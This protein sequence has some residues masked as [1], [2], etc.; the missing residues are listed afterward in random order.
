[1]NHYGVMESLK[2][3]HKLMMK[4]VFTF[5]K[6]YGGDPDDLWSDAVWGFLQAYQTQDDNRASF[7]TWVQKRVWYEMLNSQRRRRRSVPTIPLTDEVIR[8]ERF[9]PQQFREGL[10]SNA[11]IIVSIALN[12][13]ETIDSDNPKTLR[14]RL[15]NM[16]KTI[17]WTMRQIKE[18]FAE[19]REALK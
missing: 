1:M 10:S 14:K 16:L 15:R 8:S 18:S 19:I 12:P 3:V 6:R 17:G 4:T 5:R 13:P 7:V 11:R 9:D 2:D